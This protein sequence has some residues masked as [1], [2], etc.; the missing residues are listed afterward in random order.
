MAA[1][2][3]RTD[4]EIARRFRPG[5]NVRVVL[6]VGK[7]DEAVWVSLCRIDDT[8]LGH[9]VVTSNG[10]VARLRDEHVEKD[11]RHTEP[12]GLVRIPS[13]DDGAW[14]SATSALDECRRII[15]EVRAACDRALNHDREVAVLP[16]ARRVLEITEGLGGDGGARSDSPPEGAVKVTGPASVGV[17][18]HDMGA[19]GEQMLACEG[20]EREVLDF[21]VRQVRARDGQ[22][23]VVNF[24]SDDDGEDCTGIRMVE[25]GARGDIHG[26]REAAASAKLEPISALARDEVCRVFEESR[27][28]WSTDIGAIAMT[29]GHDVHSSRV[30]QM[31]LRELAE[32]VWPKDKA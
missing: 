13:L 32:R 10:W 24:Y 20:S 3:R 29:M 12:A 18:L 1:T 28:S 27:R 30:A 22:P 16:F 17:S 26:A 21:I 14:K 8:H 31:A 6:S 4:E 19:A 7:S 9:Y 25:V 23:V 2:K 11:E 15:R 5:D